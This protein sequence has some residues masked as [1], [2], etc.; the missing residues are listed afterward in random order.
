[1]H[2]PKFFDHKLLLVLLLKWD[3][4]KCSSIKKHHLM[5][6]ESFENWLAQLI[7]SKHKHIFY[8]INI[9]ILENFGKSI[10]VLS[11]ISCCLTT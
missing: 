1:M 11:D 4:L 8:N 6:S 3:L 7:V 9:K 10:T 2:R 5:L